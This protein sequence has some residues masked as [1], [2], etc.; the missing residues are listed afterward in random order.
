MIRKIYVS[1]TAFICQAFLV[2]FFSQMGTDVVI[3]FG[4]E[5]RFQIPPFDIAGKMHFG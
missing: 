3:F 2:R 1:I 4:L 5:A